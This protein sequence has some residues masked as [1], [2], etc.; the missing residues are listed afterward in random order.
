MAKAQNPHP[1][2]AK[3]K[4]AIPEQKD[5]INVI[6]ICVLKSIR[7]VKYAR[8]TTQKELNIKFRP[9]TRVKIVNLGS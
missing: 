2:Y 9:I 7:M 6:L 5:A 8:C 1:L 4:A 3:N